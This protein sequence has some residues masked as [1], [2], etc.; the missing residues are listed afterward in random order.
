MQVS[1]RVV[2]GERCACGHIGSV[3]EA[4][5]HRALCPDAVHHLA[6]WKRWGDWIVI[7]LRPREPPQRGATMFEPLFEPRRERDDM[8][9]SMMYAYWDLRIAARNRGLRVSDISA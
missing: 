6:S 3:T 1:V 2:E 4:V 8:Y 9:D 7:E 5:K